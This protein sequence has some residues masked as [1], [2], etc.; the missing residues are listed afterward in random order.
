MNSLFEIG[1]KHKTDKTSHNYLSFYDELL[2]PLRLELLRFLEVGVAFGYSLK[3]WE[4]YFPNAIIYGADIDD[5]KEYETKRTKIFVI[6]QEKIEELM[7]LPNNLDVILDDGGH[8]MLQ[9]QITLNTLFKHKLKPGG[10]FILEDLQTSISTQN[11]FQTPTNNT[12]KLLNDLK[13][14][15]LSEDSNFFITEEDF[16]E[17]VNQIES[18]EI[19]H[20]R[21]DYNLSQDAFK[22]SITAIIKR[23]K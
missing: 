23:K 12:I 2:S 10:I 13:N 6:N 20:T 21:N 19:L 1:L 7:T 5:K 22:D 8:T 18:L 11:F 3:M 4:E 16:Y 17:L 9:Q 15:K 14:K